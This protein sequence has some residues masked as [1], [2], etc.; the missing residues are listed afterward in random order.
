MV[1]STDKARY[2]W[3]L[4]VA[5]EQNYHFININAKEF[6]SHEKEYFTSTL[7][8]ALC[9]FYF[10]DSYKLTV[11]ESIAFAKM[12]QDSPHR[13][14]LSSPSFP[15]YIL[16]KHCLVKPLGEAKDEVSFALKQLQTNPDRNSVRLLI[17]NSDP[18]HLFH[19]LKSGAWIDQNQLNTMIRISQ[20]IY[21]SNSS[22]ILDMLVFAL[23]T[24]PFRLSKKPKVDEMQISILK[25]LK[26]ALPNYTSSE[27]ADVYLLVDS[28]LGPE[29]LDLSDEEKAYLGLKN[30]VEQTQETFIKA[31]NLSDYF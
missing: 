6:A 20:N 14:V 7:D 17:S 22:Y 25:K 29:K 15:N 26:K 13:F 28:A 1:G 30:E 3:A 10:E 19:I 9:L 21:K 27:I 24:K 16:Q 12:I 31:V 8:E 23:K 4:N 2:D 18:I 11:P 5:R